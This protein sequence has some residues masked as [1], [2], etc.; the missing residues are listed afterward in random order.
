VDPEAR[1][2]RVQPGVLLG[3]LDAAT[4]PF[5]LA[6]PA[7]IVTHTGVAGLTLGGGIGWIQRKY[8]LTIDQLLSVEVVTADGELLVA[9]EGENPDLFWGVRGEAATSASSRSS[10]SAWFPWAHGAGGTRLLA[11][12][13]GAEGPSLLPGLD[14]GL[15]RRAHDDRHAATG[16]CPAGGPAEL[17]GRPVVGVA[18]C[19]AGPVEEVRRYCDLLRRS[20]HPYWTCASPSR[21]S[22]TR[23]PSTPRSPRRLVLRP[24]L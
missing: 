11:D 16:T 15:P 14:R 22:P 1:T 10:S 19:Y 12:G 18:A 24:L 7:G 17:V 8:G 9:S 3:E 5:G 20:G 4:Q 2:A 13:G 6:V 23:A 21:S